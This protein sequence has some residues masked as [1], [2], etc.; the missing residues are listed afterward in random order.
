MSRPPLQLLDAVGT[1]LFVADSS[2][3]AECRQV[4]R[5]V[6]VRLDI[7]SGARLSVRGPGVDG[8]A[9]VPA[10][11][12]TVTVDL[13]FATSLAVGSVVAAEVTLDLSEHP[14]WR[15]ELALTVAEPG[16][17][18]HL[19]P[20]FHVDPVW[21]NTQAA[22]V[23]EW[24]DRQWSTAPQLTFQKSAV[25][26]LRDHL[27][28]ALADPDYRFVVAEIDYLQPFRNLYPEY[29][30]VLRGLIEAGRV[31]VVG[32]T[33]NEPDTTLPSLETL[34]RNLRYGLQYQRDVLGATVTTAWMLDVFGHA[35]QFP[36]LAAEAGLTSVALARGPF[37]QWGPLHDGPFDAMRAA[38]R[39]H[40]ADVRW[41][42]PG[43]ASMHLHALPG[44]YTA[45]HPLDGADTVEAAESLLLHW[46][47]LL[48]PHADAHTVILPVGTD[49][50]PP[51]R[52]ATELP[53]HLAAR[54]VW[55]R[56]VCDTPS[57]AFAAIVAADGAL[58]RHTR[59][60]NPIYTGKDVTYADVKGAHSR[61]ERL[62]LD[63][64]MWTALGGQTCWEQ[65]RDDIGRAWRLLVWLSHHD[66]ITGTCSDQVFIDLLGC[67]REAHDLAA[68]VL[69][70]A[71]AHVA[72]P[73]GASG[74]PI[75]VL[76]GDG[77]D[78]GGL[79][80]VEVPEPLVRNGFRIV[81]ADGSP[82]PA[83]AHDAPA[84]AGPVR[85]TLRVRDV[86]AVGSVVHRLVPG[87]GVPRWRR[88]PG[89]HLGNDTVRLRVDPD[90]GGGI[91]ELTDLT[92]G[93]Q[94]VAAGE[95][96][97][98]LVVD[99]EYPTHPAFG[100]GPWHL[101]PTGVRHRSIALVADIRRE[102]SDVGERLVVRGPLPPAA[103]AH[104]RHETT[105]LL[106]AG[107]G[108]LQVSHRLHGLTVDHRLIRAR[109]PLP[110]PGARPVFGVGEAVIGRG[111]G[112]PRSD[113]AVHPWTL[114][115]AF[116]GWCGL[117][118]T[119]RVR[120][121][122]GAEVAERAVGAV[123]IIVPDGRSD[124]LVAADRLVVALGRSGVTATITAEADQ[125]C[126]N[127]AVD[128]NLVDLRLVLDTV[129]PDGTPGCALLRGR[130]S[131]LGVTAPPVGV[132]WL[133]P[134]HPTADVWRP[135]ADLR[136]VGCLP[137]LTVTAL[138]VAGLDEA[139]DTLC[140]ELDDHHTLT[141]DTP[142]G[143]ADLG[144]APL[145][146]Y[147]V[148]IASVDVHSAVVDTA[149]CLEVNLHRSCTSWPAGQ[150]IDP[151]RRMLP[152]GAPFGAQRWTVEM[153]Y[154]VL[155]GAG[156]WRESGVAVA[157]RH[158][159]RPLRAQPAGVGGGPA[160]ST[161]GLGGMSFGPAV[162]ESV[163]R[164]DEG[165]LAVRVSH[166]G[167]RQLEV[168]LPATRQAWAS[169]LWEARGAALH[170]PS[171]T[172]SL[173][174]PPVSS[175]T[176]VL[177]DRDDLPPADVPAA[178]VLVAGVPARPVFSRWWTQSSGPAPADGLPVAVYLR[179]T[180]DRVAAMV[181]SDCATAV[182]VTVLLGVGS[183]TPLASVWVPAG[184]HVAVP[185]P[186]DPAG[187]LVAVTAR[188]AETT[189]PATW[190]CLDLG[191]RRAVDLVRWRTISTGVVLDP[192][193]RGV[194]TVELGWDGDLAVPYEAR[195]AAPP[196]CWPV[197]PQ[198]T[199]T[200]QIGPGDRIRW[201]FPVTAESAAAG[202]W[203]VVPTVTLLDRVFYGET[204]A[205]VVRDGA[206][207]SA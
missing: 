85:L 6:V 118:S 190:D 56:V 103:G 146:S 92:T 51:V 60:L 129:A 164:N 181:V 41:T 154:T 38:E 172:R 131:A 133:A 9:D 179:R 192:G 10:G 177:D 7:V 33:W 65:H 34:R 3:G 98:E 17:S 97:G 167:S 128:S 161:A 151:P 122:A 58:R 114:D 86:P 24:A 13:P 196:D 37:H 105:Y 156:D 45:G 170:S 159:T 25:S 18:V 31:E 136:P 117:S 5:V 14:T 57:R 75:V 108:P 32:G 110:V 149:G 115:S 101:L 16:W 68:A 36:A 46:L 113:T 116:T 71:F 47:S 8:Q 70:E 143:A 204:V 166:L 91:V 23:T 48:R 44:H 102:V 199:S 207:A 109:W 184:G 42:A 53:R 30:T 61:T 99:E 74:E 62:L 180:G 49:L 135:G 137:L 107:D 171:G 138:D 182:E 28:R 140:A 43:G 198:A 125:R 123:E 96:A 132:G 155:A 191:L 157:A 1:E 63:A 39:Q 112:F 134:D 22:T 195:L 189:L 145:E 144:A 12:G 183:T 124:L 72:V 2:A 178:D 176:V 175:A 81:G 119:V 201:D 188:P 64:E 120:V 84:G 165:L 82:V 90:R 173:T 89:V 83:V 20:H 205:V 200:G 104:S 168:A 148:A 40:A 185:V 206:R 80:P 187:G 186:T 202:E 111:H 94:L 78:R 77:L 93:R 141:V 52:W 150:W 69:R 66:S 152:D 73:V 54:Y 163:R 4:I 194:V 127:L 142:T 95:V 26:V 67:W 153:G 79:V 130:L 27:I 88:E 203:W 158:A 55:P 147:T 193:G 35:P 174:V 19:L 87:A 169:D 197:L 162:I 139:V 50:A 29:R 76:N 106:P 126:G 100:E 15:Q 160:A 11:L 121:T 59:D 21:W